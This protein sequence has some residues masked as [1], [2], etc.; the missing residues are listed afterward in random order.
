MQK[1][2]SL[3]CGVFF[4]YLH[5]RCA[6]W[7]M[8]SLWLW[9]KT[10]FFQSWVIQPGRS[11]NWSPCMTEKWNLRFTRRDTK[12]EW[13]RFIC[14]RGAFLL[15]LLTAPSMNLNLLHWLFAASERVEGGDR[16]AKVTIISW[17]EANGGK[18]LD[19]VCLLIFPLDLSTV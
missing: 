17:C 10:L 14:C 18:Y 7:L 4:F 16:D 8:F 6:V 11:Y 12:Q 1:Q 5:T 9:N 2:F 15:L 3:F 19:F 13:L